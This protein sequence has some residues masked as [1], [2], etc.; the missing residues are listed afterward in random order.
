MVRYIITVVLSVAVF[1]YV[2]G[3]IFSEKF[4]QYGDEKKAG[5]TCHVNN[6][7]VEYHILLSE[8]KEAQMVCE[9]TVKRCPKTDVSRKAEYKIAYCLERRG[10]LQDA[11]QAYQNFLEK[12]PKSERA[13]L[14]QRKISILKMS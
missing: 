2:W 14:A 13:K 1:M 9:R 7:I 8:Y 6:F 12:Y 11:L 10:Q 4:Q 5:W 3:F